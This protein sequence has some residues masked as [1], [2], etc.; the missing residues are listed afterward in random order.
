MN[1]PKMAYFAELIFADT[2]SLV[3]IE[4]RKTPNLVPGYIQL[5]GEIRKNKSRKNKF[6]TNLFRKQFLP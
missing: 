4:I 5:L 6:R 3:K 1:D 2:R